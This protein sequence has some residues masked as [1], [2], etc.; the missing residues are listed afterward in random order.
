MSL[1]RFSS[2]KPIASR[3]AAAPRV[4]SSTSTSSSRRHILLGTSTLLALSQCEGALADGKQSAVVAEYSDRTSQV[5]DVSK[6]PQAKAYLHQPGFVSKKRLVGMLAF[7]VNFSG[8]SSSKV[9]RG[10]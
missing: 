9:V 3:R 2:L 7:I 8:L 1:V 5:A 6:T 10:A 4:T